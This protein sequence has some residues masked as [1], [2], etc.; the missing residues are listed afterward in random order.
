MEKLPFYENIRYRRLEFLSTPLPNISITTPLPSIN[1]LSKLM[2]HLHKMVQ[3]PCHTTN[4]R[5][6]PSL[7]QEFNGLHINSYH[8]VKS[9][10]PP[11]KKE[12]SKSWFFF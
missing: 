6:G 4:N 7:Y 5:Y 10:P 2:E 12:P 3:D 1:T 9:S 11:P 8:W